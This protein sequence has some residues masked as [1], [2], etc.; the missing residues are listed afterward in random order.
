MARLRPFRFGVFAEGVRSREA[1]LDTAR[2]AEAGDSPPSCSG[3]TSLPSPSAISW[4]R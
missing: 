4:P 1:L 3:T 2:R